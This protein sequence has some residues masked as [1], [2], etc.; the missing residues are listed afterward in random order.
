MKFALASD[1]HNE[2]Y[3]VPPTL[4]VVDADVLILAGD[5]ETVASHDNDWWDE[6]CSHYKT[7]IYIRGN[8]EYYKTYYQDFP[9]L[10]YP[11]NVLAVGRMPTLIHIDRFRILAGTMWTNLHNPVSAEIAM[12]H[13]NDYRLIKYSKDRSQF[14]TQDTTREHYSFMSALDE[15]K[16]NVVISHHLP[17]YWSIHPRYRHDFLNA[18]FATEMNMTG[19]KLWVHG[20]THEPCDY[21]KD[22]TRVVCNPQGYPNGEARPNYKPKVIEI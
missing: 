18:A 10:Y 5:I 7:V 19:V 8:H 14:S 4:P 3:R 21:V 17:S 1:L 13:M 11:D 6:T 20:H 12:T 15:D 16:P 2:F 9:I 22:G